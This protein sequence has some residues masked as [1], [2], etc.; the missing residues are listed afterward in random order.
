MKKQNTNQATLKKKHSKATN[1]QKNVSKPTQSLLT[2]QLS[3]RIEKI[4]GFRMIV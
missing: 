3:K 2:K 1:K 4:I